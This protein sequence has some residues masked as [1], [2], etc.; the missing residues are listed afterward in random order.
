MKAKIDLLQI[1]AWLLESATV[2]VPQMQQKYGLSYREAV[3]IVKQLVAQGC[4]SKNA[5][6]IL[7][8]VIPDH[9]L[10][11]R[12]EREEVDSLY[13][14]ID[15]IGAQI[16]YGLYA[17]GS[18]T[19][20]NV[21]CDEDNEEYE[22]G[23]AFRKLERR[24]LIYRYEDAYFLRI[25]RRAAKVL[26]DMGFAKANK[27]HWIFRRKRGKAEEMKIKRMLDILFER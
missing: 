18:I 14:D 17:R 6:G 16:L 3:A 21:F 23:I 5:D 10:F 9:L 1:Q 20:A 25:S 2:S 8:T 24:R 15:K 11:R 13:A 19:E 27:K 26:S 4:L 22:I 12:L 7:Y